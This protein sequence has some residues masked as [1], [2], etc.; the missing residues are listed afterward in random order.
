M[1]GKEKMEICITFNGNQEEMRRACE[2]FFILESIC[3]QVYLLLEP[4]WG[5]A[6]KV[7]TAPM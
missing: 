5:T 7:I 6:F 1:Y 2:I 3:L 4:V